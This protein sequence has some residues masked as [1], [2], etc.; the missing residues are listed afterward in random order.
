MLTRHVS[1]NLLSPVQ[2]KPG[3][4]FASSPELLNSSF[5]SIL[6]QTTPSQLFSN[7]LAPEL[8]TKR[9]VQQTRIQSLGADQG[10]SCITRD[11]VQISCD[12]QYVSQLWP[13]FYSPVGWYFSLPTHTTVLMVP[14]KKL[15]PVI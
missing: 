8:K 15:N 4:Y 3:Q 12:A 5:I 14:S 11:E 10:I 2:Q 13:L 6:I 9:A 1:F 7:P